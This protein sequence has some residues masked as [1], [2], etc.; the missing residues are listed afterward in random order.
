MEESPKCHNIRIVAL[1]ERNKNIELKLIGYVFIKDKTQVVFNPAINVFRNLHWTWHESGLVHSKA[2][3]RVYNRFK[4]QRL[5]KFKRCEQFLY[6]CDSVGVGEKINYTLCKN[7]Q[8]FLI[9]ARGFKKG[10]GLSIHL[11]DYNN[12]NLATKAFSDEPTHQ[13]FIFWKSKPKVVI[14]I[15]DK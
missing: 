2:D 1:T 9:D 10:I 14:N 7:S 13:S 12:V 15:I 11:S 4:R 5:D 6:M 8:I 3:G